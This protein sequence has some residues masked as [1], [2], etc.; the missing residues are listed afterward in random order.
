M[1]NRRG[2]GLVVLAAALTVVSLIQDYT[3]QP[4]TVLSAGALVW[5]VGS[6]Y[7]AVAAILIV[8]A[9]ITTLWVRPLSVILVLGALLISMAGL[10]SGTGPGDLSLGFFAALTLLFVYV[11]ASVRLPVMGWIGTLSHNAKSWS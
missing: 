5:P 2:W 10:P 8:A 9:L 3:D 4:G 7:Y 6:L 11:F 1:L